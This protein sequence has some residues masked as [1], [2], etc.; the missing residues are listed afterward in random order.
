[1]DLR[2]DFAR[3]HD[4]FCLSDKAH[5]PTGH[6]VRRKGFPMSPLDRNDR[7][8][9]P[10]HCIGRAEMFANRAVAIPR[11]AG[12]AR[13]SEKGAPRPS[14]FAAARWKTGA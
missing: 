13:R 3:T 4:G 7:R 5:G 2:S 1:M 10:K 8:P 6:S 14:I 12:Q 11:P 9:I